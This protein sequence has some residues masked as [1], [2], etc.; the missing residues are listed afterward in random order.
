MSGQEGG[1]SPEFYGARCSTTN[2]A[3]A[4]AEKKLLPVPAKYAHDVIGG[5]QRKAFSPHL[6][7][8]TV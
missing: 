7:K 1:N 4:A 5:Q 2:G 6:K 3:V 8:L